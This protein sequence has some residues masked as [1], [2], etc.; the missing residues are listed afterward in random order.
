M[1]PH[2]HYSLAP[3]AVLSAGSWHSDSALPK[4]AAC[5]VQLSF[6]LGTRTTNHSFPDT[7]LQLVCSPVFTGLQACRL[8]KS[9]IY[10]EIP[11]KFVFSTVYALWCCCRRVGVFQ[12]RIEHLLTTTTTETARSP[13]LFCI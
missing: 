10:T 1:C 6:L 9:I 7:A 12:L 8:I 2:L 4:K 5:T 3:S 13:L 11:I